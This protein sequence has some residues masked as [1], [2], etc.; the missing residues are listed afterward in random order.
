MHAKPAKPSTWSAHPVPSLIN[1]PLSISTLIMCLHQWLH[2]LARVTTTL[3]VYYCISMLHS[4][5]KPWCCTHGLPSRSLLGIMPL[6]HHQE[7][8][9]HHNPRTQGPHP[10][11]LVPMVHVMRLTHEF[12]ENSSIF[13]YFSNEAQNVHCHQTHHNLTSLVKGHWPE[14]WGRAPKFYTIHLS[15]PVIQQ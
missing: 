1:Q 11:T 5:N 15:N 8:S 10:W 13:Q 3:Y 14:D 7:G 6:C 12:L 9:P 4:D 2:V